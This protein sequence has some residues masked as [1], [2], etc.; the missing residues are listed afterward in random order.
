MYKGFDDLIR[1]HNEYVVYEKPLAEMN[2]GKI[3]SGSK[4]IVIAPTA[5]LDRLEKEAVSYTH[6]DVYKRQPL[7]DF[8]LVQKKI[9]MTLIWLIKETDG[10][11][12]TIDYERFIY[13]T[14]AKPKSLEDG[15]RLIRQT[16]RKILSLSIT[17]VSYTHLVVQK[18][19]RTCYN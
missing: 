9:L 3:V 5:V 11:E 4:Y 2:N 8:S 1:R 15:I 6:L 7:K 10:S 12:I 16:F 14:Q 18:K 19:Y 13:L 17:A